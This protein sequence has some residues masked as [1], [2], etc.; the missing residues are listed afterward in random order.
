MMRAG[1]I[2]LSVQS[3]EETKNFSVREIRENSIKK[4]IFYLTSSAYEAAT[5]NPIMLPTY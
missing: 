5:D 4:I 2:K 1:N 3:W